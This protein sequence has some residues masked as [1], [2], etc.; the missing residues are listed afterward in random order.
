MIRLYACF[1]LHFN[2]YFFIVCCCTERAKI[3]QAYCKMSW[4]ISVRRHWR[5]HER[6][7]KKLWWQVLSII[8]TIE[9]NEMTSNKLIASIYWIQ[10][11]YVNML[12][13]C[14]CHLQNYFC[15]FYFLLHIR[16]LFIQLHKKSLLMPL[17]VDNHLVLFNCY[18]PVSHTYTFPFSYSH[19][20]F[21]FW[22][23]K[24]N[25]FAFI[26]NPLVYVFYVNMS[27]NLNLSRWL[28]NLVTREYKLVLSQ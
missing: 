25:L 6:E 5:R 17:N 19:F 4:Q 14:Y 7:E 21:N 20:H 12:N 9:R 23:R 1:I 11:H 15:Y 24:K 13:Y 28:I 8:C 26:S 27:F 16:K 22:F 3:R 2:L 10:Y 18:V